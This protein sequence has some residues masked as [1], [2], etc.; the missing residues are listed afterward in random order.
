MITIKTMNWI[1]FTVALLAFGFSTLAMAAVQVDLAVQ[2]SKLVVTG[3]NAQCSGGPV[4]C[5]DVAKA[6]KPNL[7]FNLPGA[8]GSQGPQFRLAAFRIGM[9]SKVWP[10]PANPLPANVAADFAANPR[11]GYV[12]LNHDTNQLRNDKMKL[13][14]K[15][16][17]AYSVYYDI[18]AAHCTDMTAGD[19]HLDPE[20]KNRGGN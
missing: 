15:N 12:D 6:T 16:G 14:N 18:T 20:I 19:I 13:K 11:T 5:I 7:F 9:Q 17:S 8:C 1:K 4:D 2:G 3:N 10:T